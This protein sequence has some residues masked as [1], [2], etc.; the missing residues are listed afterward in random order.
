M[1]KIFIIHGWT[2]TTD[3]W[4]ALL[5]V[6]RSRGFEPI[7]LSV[8]GLTTASTDVWTVEKYIAWLKK[9]IAD[10]PQ[11]TLV[12]HSNGGR[13]AMAFAATY[14]ERVAH[15][16]LINAAGVVH[17]EFPLRAKRAVFKAITKVGKRMTSSPFVRKIFYRLISA[18]DYERASPTMR[19]TMRNLIAYDATA[20]LPRITAPTLIIW[21]A[22]DTVTPLADAY[23]LH[24]G[25]PRSEVIVIPDG[26]HSPH[27]TH[28]EKVGALIADSLTTAPRE[29]REK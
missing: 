3:A 20:L 12:G 1:Q 21:S 16:F 14:P 19:E 5:R 28:P 29:T 11:V 9:Q 26:A 18:R 23:L 4:N 27:A 24:N 6:L 10:E 25:I 8:P 17:R 2:Y 22:K 15:L 13:I 7:L